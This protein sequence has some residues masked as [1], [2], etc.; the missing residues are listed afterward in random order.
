MAGTEVG[1][2]PYRHRP[3]PRSLGSD[4]VPPPATP[5]GTNAS[6]AG[7]GDGPRSDADLVQSIANGD[8]AALGQL[9]DRHA[10]L[11]L[12]VARR[13]LRSGS[14]AEDLVHDVFLE[15][16]RHAKHFDGARGT[17]R[18]WLVVRVRSRALD[19]LKS[20]A[21]T[22]VVS[23]ETTTIAVEP[24]VEPVDVT[25]RTEAAV[26]QRALDRLAPAQR[27]VVELG[28]FEGLSLSDIAE[29]LATPVGT[30]KSRLARALTKLREDLAVLDREDHGASH[31]L[32]QPTVSSE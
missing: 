32:A 24:S 3:L 8:R 21:A 20:G 6:F 11:L 17:V 30:I 31:P 7:A 16:W 18:A 22:R 25:G 9:Y 1:R 13:V 26:V 5:A 23:L 27:E 2:P 12:G 14:E 28:Y 15:A 19:R 10:P 29:R 4:F